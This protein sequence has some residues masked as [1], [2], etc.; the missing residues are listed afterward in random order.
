[1][2]YVH[3]RSRARRRVAFTR[4]RYI[5]PALTRRALD[6]TRRATP[7][8]RKPRATRLTPGRYELFLAG[9]DHA[10]LAA[11]FPEAEVSRAGGRCRL[12]AVFD[13]ESLTTVVQRIALLGGRVLGI[14][15]VDR[16]AMLGRS[17]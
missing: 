4:G 15:S 3:G 12:L 17:W 10:A 6:L 2:G 14:W 5:R 8:A 16:L 13:D 7:D 9:I 11:A 1:M